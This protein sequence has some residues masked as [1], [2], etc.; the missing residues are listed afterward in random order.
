MPSL[1]NENRLYVLYFFAKGGITQ[2][3]VKTVVYFVKA[4]LEWK[5]IL[6]Q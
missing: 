2:L 3:L 5:L 1:L 4:R 6:C